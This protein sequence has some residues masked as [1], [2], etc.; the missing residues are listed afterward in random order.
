LIQQGKLNLTR[1]LNERITYH[2]SCYLGRHNG[3][4]EAPRKV[5]TA[6]PGV[7][8]VEMPRHEENAFCCGAGGGR[9]W[10][11]ETLGTRINHERAEEAIGVN[12]DVVA[13]ACPFCH[14]MLDD[15]LKD[16]GKENIQTL[17]IVQLVAEAIAE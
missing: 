8:M 10:M 6:I 9:M 5:L 2:D 12:P 1:S 17:D 15:G 16:K 13:T 3:I 7:K 11:E 4:Y 14:T